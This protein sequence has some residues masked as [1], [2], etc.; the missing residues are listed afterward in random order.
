HD[1]L[2]HVALKVEN[3][4][5]VTVIILRPEM[6]TIAHIDE[7]CRDA[8]FLAGFAHASFQDRAHVQLIADFAKDVLFVLA[9]ERKTACSSWH[10]RSEERRVGKGCS[11]RW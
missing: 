9:L 10:A 2:G 11:S 8:Q 5:Y 6:I 7:L 3:V 1:L 4:F